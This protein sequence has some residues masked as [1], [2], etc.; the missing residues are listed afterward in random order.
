MI[1]WYEVTVGDVKQYERSD[2]DVDF[3][4]G[5]IIG[6]IWKEGRELSLRQLAVL[7]VCEAASEPQTIRE[8]ALLLKVCK[9]VVTRAVDR[10]E[11]EQ[12]VERQPDPRDGRSILIVLTSSGHHY[13]LQFFGR[14]EQG[15]VA[16]VQAQDIQS[17]P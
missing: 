1:A 6:L 8:L 2:K 13:C 12:L 16:T 11:K 10:L 15:S 3:F 14:A 9:P 7:L 5:Q 17:C 4:F